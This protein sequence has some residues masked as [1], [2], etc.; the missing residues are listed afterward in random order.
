MFGKILKK[1]TPAAAP[2][3]APAQT[4]SV[5]K[6]MEETEEFF[7]P[8]LGLDVADYIKA[9]HKQ[10]IH[11]VGRYHWAA[12]VLDGAKGKK[13]LDI[14]C[15]A[16]YGSRILA[17]ALPECQIQGGD[18]DP[19]AVEHARK[20]YSAPNLNYGRADI[21]SWMNLDTE[22]SLGQVDI[23]T[24][25]DTME[26]LLHREICWMNIVEHLADDGVLLFST[27]VKKAPILNPG[28]EHHKLEYSHS[29]LKNLVKRMFRE[30][31]IPGDEGF[32]HMDFWDNVINKDK[33]R[34]LT[35]TNPIVCRGPIKFGL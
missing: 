9:E 7:T 3:H 18:Y 8:H 5:Q 24:S 1:A 10:G 16:G 20:N 21:V 23:I 28:W 30:V 25:F 2:K 12:K 22:E 13:L 17:G 27:P 26:H 4:G 15:G 34:Y 29:F 11:H 35:R 31:L 14:V 6:N 32:P 19:R 33:Q